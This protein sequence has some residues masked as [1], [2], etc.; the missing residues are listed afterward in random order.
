LKNTLTLI[1][2]LLVLHLDGCCLNRCFC[3]FFLIFFSCFETGCQRNISPQAQHA[4][5]FF[6]NHQYSEAVI[7]FS[8]LLEKF[9]KDPLYQYYLGASLVE[10]NSSPLRANECLQ[11]ATLKNKIN[12]AWFY[13]GLNY[14][15]QFR[16]NESEAAFNEF[17]KNAS[18]L[19]NRNMETA[20]ELE[21][22]KF[23]PGFFSNAISMTITNEKI[24]S[25]D[26][27]YPLIGK[28]CKCQETTGSGSVQSEPGNFKKSIKIGEFY[29]YSDFSRPATRGKDI[30][31]IQKISDS[32]WSEPQNLGTI[33]NTAEDEDFP[34]FD[35]KTGTLYFASKGHES[36]GGFDIF[37]S[38]YDSINKKW[39]TPLRL[40]FPINSP[41]DDYGWIEDEKSACFASNRENLSG[42][43]TVYKIAKP[44]SKTKILISGSTYM[45]QTC[46]LKMQKEQGEKLVQ[47]NINTESKKD[48]VMF[49]GNLLMKLVSE[50]L[51]MQKNCDSV[52]LD[53]K[54]SKL[55][56][57]NT[58]DKEKRAFLFSKIKQDEKYYLKAQNSINMIYTEV[59]SLQ[60]NLYSKQS[61]FKDSIKYEK[62]NFSIDDSVV[63]S[64]LNPIPS[65]IIIPEGIVYRIQLGVYSKPIDYKLFGGI[66]PIS[67]EF[68]QDKKII[69]YYVGVFKTY[70]EAD[71]SL[72]K[73]KEFGFKEAFIIAYYNK[74]KIPVD[75]AKEFEKNQ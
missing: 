40:P 4:V 61:A 55:L 19:E 44:L 8:K 52:I 36:V 1:P 12:K 41:W 23:A 35:Y 46:M 47:I 48:T 73:V 17:N 37:Q 22:F 54:K 72:N 32:A 74:K 66:R 71:N 34:Y 11:A 56:L 15:R 69:K 24:I 53:S 60:G 5:N 25:A 33:I 3:I 9:P 59:N 30:Y 64:K 51:A 28:I 10:L 68:L 62:N 67:I 49:T 13:L 31:R 7:E 27:L 2:G 75:R 63:Y 38:V 45:L 70:N 14:Y 18:W 26:S 20:K 6:D 39:S 42:F 43:L 21:R 58:N 16:F 57:D 65:D 50:A 29:Y